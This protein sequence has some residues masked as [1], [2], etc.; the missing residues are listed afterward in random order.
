MKQVA[1]L[2]SVFQ[3]LIG[4][5]FGENLGNLLRALH[6][7]YTCN[8]GLEKLLGILLIEDGLLI[9]DDSTQIPM[10]NYSGAMQLQEVQENKPSS[11]RA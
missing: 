10:L 2:T 1:E 5:Q 8:S 3:V 6:S 4:E 11:S 7:N 9:K